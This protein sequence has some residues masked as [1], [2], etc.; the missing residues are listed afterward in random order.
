MSTGRQQPH[1]WCLSRSALSKQAMSSKT[2]WAKENDVCGLQELTEARLQARLRE[3]YP[4]FVSDSKGFEGHGG[5]GDSGL[6][7]TK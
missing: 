6:Y 1:S 7:N 5:A 2:F 4:I 3:F